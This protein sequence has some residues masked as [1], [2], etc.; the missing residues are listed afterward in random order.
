MYNYLLKVPSFLEIFSSVN[1]RAKL[2]RVEDNYHVRYRRKEKHKA[3]KV[4]QIMR[5]K[6]FANTFADDG[7][8]LALNIRISLLHYL[9]PFTINASCKHEK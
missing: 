9:L 5:V 1:L 8:S 3:F 7:F 4:L 2:L 6:E